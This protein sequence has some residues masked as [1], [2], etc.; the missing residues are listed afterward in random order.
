MDDGHDQAVVRRYRDTDVHVVVLLD[1]SIPP[2]HIDARL[3]TDRRR[4]ELDEE[5][6]IGWSDVRT[7]RYSRRDAAV[8]VAQR[9]G[10]DLSHQREVRD[11]APC[12]GHAL[13]H[14]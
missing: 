6:G 11:G 1:G 13:G 7:L 9:S 2:A 5:I 14:D 12:G 10:L 3:T 4:D 8:H